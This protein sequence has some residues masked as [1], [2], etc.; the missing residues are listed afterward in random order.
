[1]KTLH[2]ISDSKIQHTIHLGDSNVLNYQEAI[3]HL[4]SEAT[5]K[6]N[7][8]IICNE[9]NKPSTYI[10]FSDKD[11][12]AATMP[13]HF[14]EYYYWIMIAIVLAAYIYKPW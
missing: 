6:D 1:M 13:P 2:L 9:E 8:I 12:K 7:T 10:E 3:E 14:P 11:V 4:K 5:G